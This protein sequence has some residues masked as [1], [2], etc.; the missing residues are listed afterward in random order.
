MSRKCNLCG[1]KLVNNRCELCGLDN[2][3]Y[4]RDNP[5]MQ[6]RNKSG[7]ERPVSS[8]SSGNVKTPRKVSA[9]P[10]GAGTG[11]ART[12]ASGMQTPLHPPTSF[13][14]KKKGN[15][16][17]KIVILLFIILVI[18]IPLCISLAEV[19][20]D[21]MSYDF[22]FSD[23]SD[24]YEYVTRE[25]PS[26]GENC[27]MLLGNGCYQ[28]GAQIPEGTYSIEL[29][30]GSGSISLDDSENIIYE[31][32]SFGHDEDYD[33]ITSID[34]FRLYNG[35]ELTVN[36]GVLLKFTSS[37]A[38]PLIYE[39]TVNPVSETFVL[40][41]GTTY[42][43][44]ESRIPEGMYDIMP[45]EEKSGGATSVQLEYPNE[46]SN[47]FWIENIPFEEEGIT[48]EENGAV[49]VVIPSGTKIEIS[50]SPIILVPS[51]KYYDIDFDNYP[52]Y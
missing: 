12:F 41:E 42:T 29:A 26:D 49:N 3:V 14:S 5:H 25:I 6:Y 22:S 48:Y 47:S 10:A 13:Q 11:T 16:I 31:F 51:E 35:A 40:E 44:G 1:G 36:S 33:E 28:I 21:R 52:N 9:P 45:D 43:T 39:A 18:F 50:G 7:S 37:N 32:L 46:F 38:Q 23:D 4:D 34:D 2:T 30:A 19:I 17:A 15:K 20:N 27:E 8:A 24:P